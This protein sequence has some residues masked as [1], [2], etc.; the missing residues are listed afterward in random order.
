MEELLAIGIFLW[1]SGDTDENRE[2][3]LFFWSISSSRLSVRPRAVDTDL[4]RGDMDSSTCNVGDLCSIPGS[5]RSSGEGHATHSNINAWRIPWTEKPGGLQFMGSQR[6]RHDWVA[7]TF[8]LLWE[9]VK[10]IDSPSKKGSTQSIFTFNMMCT[11]LESLEPSWAHVKIS[12]STTKN[13]CS[14][15]LR[16]NKRYNIGVSWDEPQ[17]FDFVCHRTH[18]PHLAFY[19]TWEKLSYGTL[20]VND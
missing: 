5:E 18:M 3:V 14:L 7:N 4:L 16:M 13:S 2:N 11:M 1:T 17:H 9:P 19:F 20:R 12:F 15:S 8:T 10:A 6:V